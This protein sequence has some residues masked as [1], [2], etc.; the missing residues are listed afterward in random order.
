VVVCGVL[1]RLVGR[2][3]AGRRRFGLRSLGVYPIAV[4]ERISEAGMVPFG[5]PPLADLVAGEWCDVINALVVMDDGAEEVGDGE[6]EVSAV[7]SSEIR[8]VREALHRR[9]PVLA[10]AGGVIRLRSAIDPSV[11]PAPSEI[12]MNEVEPG[13][14]VTLKLTVTDR[15]LREIFGSSFTVSRPDPGA[16]MSADDGFAVAAI[17]EREAVRMATASGGAAL[18]VQW[19]PERSEAGSKAAQGPFLWLSQQARLRIEADS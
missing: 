15:T 13:A 9:L 4:M 8:V 12:R 7:R 6:D 5:I 3:D 2:Q 16:S 1:G 17:D 18:A 11:S 14:A 10:I 19:H